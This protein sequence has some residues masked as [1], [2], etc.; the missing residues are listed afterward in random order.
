MLSVMDA[1]EFDMADNVY[2]K[3]YFC[4]QPVPDSGPFDVPLEPVPM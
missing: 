4:S 2:T 3:C 1:P